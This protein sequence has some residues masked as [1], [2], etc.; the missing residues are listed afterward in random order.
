[1]VR[2]DKSCTGTRTH[3]RWPSPLAHS[4]T[5]KLRT[6]GGSVRVCS[7][8]DWKCAPPVCL[9]RV[10]IASLVLCA[11]AALCVSATGLSSAPLPATLSPTLYVTDGSTNLDDIPRGIA[12]NPLDG[13]VWITA[14][15]EKLRR[16]DPVTHSASADIHVGTSGVDVIGF[17]AAGA[18]FQLD[19]NA[20]TVYKTVF[21]DI[22]NAPT[23]GVQSVWASVQSPHT[24]LFDPEGNIYIVSAMDNGYVSQYTPDGTLVTSSYTS[25]VSNCMGGGAFDSTGTSHERHTPLR[26]GCPGPHELC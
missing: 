25:G 11:C 3:A 5:L 12:R 15:G 7:K 14:N 26:A 19:T 18:L 16:I 17:D 6:R 4:G 20:N 24:I 8:T 9:Q 13:S 21:S 1:M 10:S 23:V 22:V 2:Q